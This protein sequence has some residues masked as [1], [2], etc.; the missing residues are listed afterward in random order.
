MTIFKEFEQLWEEFERALPEL[1]EIAEQHGFSLRMAVNAS[2]NTICFYPEVDI[3]R[4]IGEQ[5]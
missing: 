5:Q 4:E 3:N 1:Q 2:Q